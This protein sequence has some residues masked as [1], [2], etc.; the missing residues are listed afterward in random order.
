MNRVRSEVTEIMPEQL[1]TGTRSN[2]EIEKLIN[3]PEQPTSQDQQQLVRL[4][5][6]RIRTKAEKREERITVKKAI[7]FRQGQL[8]LIRNHHLSN[9]MNCE[10]KKL[11]NV[12]EGPYIITKVISKNTIAIKQKRSEKETLINV[13][14]VRPYFRADDQ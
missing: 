14:E 8:V 4:A 9:A 6:D 2:Q 5:A 3:V 10:I 1:M 11:F 13:A 7:Q 12:F